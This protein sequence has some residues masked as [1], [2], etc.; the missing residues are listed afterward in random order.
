MSTKTHS[1]KHGDSISVIRV[2]RIG[3]GGIELQLDGRSYQLPFSHFPWFAGADPAAVH[4]VVRVSRNHLRWPDLDVD[5]SLD[6][7]RH[8]ER[9]PLIA[10]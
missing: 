3:T 6:S 8:P 7:I 9:Y 10:R 1:S 5:L 2:E 4:N